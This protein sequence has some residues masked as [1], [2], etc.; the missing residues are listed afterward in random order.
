MKTTRKEQMEDYTTYLKKTCGYQLSSKP[1][2]KREFHNFPRFK[3]FCCGCRGATG[4]T[5][6]TGAQGETGATGATGEQG[7][8]GVTGTTGATGATG[9]QGETGVTG[10][11]GATGEQ[12]E[13]GVTGST[14]ATGPT[15]ATGAPGATGS[16]GD[17]G[18]TGA[19]GPQ[20]I[21]ITGA[22]GATGP[23]FLDIFYYGSGV[24]GDISITGPVTLTQDL[25]ANN[26]TW[27][28][29]TLFTNNFRVFARGTVFMNTA[30]PLINVQGPTGG[31]SSGTIRGTTGPIIVGTVG[32][33]SIAGTAGG[34]NQSG[35]LRVPGNNGGDGGDGGSGSGGLTGVSTLANF[36][37]EMA[38]FDTNFLV[39][40]TTGFQGGGPGQGGSGSSAAAGAAGGQ[41]G[42][43]FYMSAKTLVVDPF[44]TSVGA[45]N[46][47]GGQ[48]GDAVSGGL[49]GGGSG[50][51]GGG[52][53]A[54]IAYGTRVG[55]TVSNMIDA[56]GGNGGSASGTPAGT[57]GGAGGGGRLQTVNIGNQTATLCTPTTPKIPAPATATGAVAT[58]WFINF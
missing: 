22:T 18:A 12:G 58:P 16:Q 41:G 47:R 40:G 34:P 55:G 43:V 45:I 39:S 57:G 32:W 11:T 5:G 13:T 24:D 52:G 35:N 1:V 20:G 15:G 38:R 30:G 25:N 23:G 6:A 51:G 50:G 2:L 14:G 33:Q 7:E 9:A 8:T 37:R 3:P 10:A 42:G 27:N 29:G 48:G 44:I 56:T 21:G 19:T 46:I 4:A 26:I 54:W 31:N 28:G 53:Y 17:T 36:F 49:V